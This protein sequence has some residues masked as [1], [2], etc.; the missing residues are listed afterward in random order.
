MLNEQD[1]KGIIVPVVAPF[2]PSEELDL[3]SYQNYLSELLVHDIQGLVI[4]GTTGESPTVHWREVEELVA[5]TKAEL[6]KQQKRVPLIIGT[7]TNNTA[8]TVNQTDMA[9][10]LGADAVLVVT[11]YYSRPSQ[12]G[13]VEHYRR[14]AQVGVPVIAYEVPSRTGVEVTAETMRRILDLN[15]VIGLKDSTGGTEL[16]SELKQDTK[17]ILCGSDINFY[18]MLSQGAAGGILASANI[19]TSALMRIYSLTFQ[20]D[21]IRAKEEFDALLP[22]IQLLFQESNPSPLKWLLARQGVISSST[23][24]LPMGPISEQFEMEWEQALHTS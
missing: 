24:R 9:G 19:Y 8:S 10:H 6:L 21:P 23:V 11:P 13:I 5:T 22:S 3:E 20:V 16:I 2:L 4:H 15:G 18:N 1:L 14:I 7:G 17:P 12:W